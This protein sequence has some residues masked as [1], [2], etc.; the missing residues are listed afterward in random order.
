MH[1]VET[2]ARAGLRAAILRIHEPLPIV[3]SRQ[4]QV[5]QAARRAGELLGRRL[6]EGHDR[7]AVTKKMQQKMMHKFKQST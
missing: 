2:F 4:P 5:L 7:A 3:V 6:R 1:N